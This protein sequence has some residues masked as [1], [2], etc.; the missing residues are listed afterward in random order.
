[1]INGSMGSQQTNSFYDVFLLKTDDFDGY[2]EYEK[3]NHREASVV[4]LLR[5]HPPS[6]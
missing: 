5:H 3:K 2:I 1:M 4:A 6:K